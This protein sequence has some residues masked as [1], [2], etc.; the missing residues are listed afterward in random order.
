MLDPQRPPFCPA[1]SFL[2]PQRLLYNPKGKLDDPM[3]LPLKNS[4]D[5]LKTIPT[6]HQDS[7]TS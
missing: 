3:L 2:T 1:G 7:L 6:L 5:K 4:L